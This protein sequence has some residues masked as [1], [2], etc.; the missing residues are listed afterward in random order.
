MCTGHQDYTNLNEMLL[1]IDVTAILDIT[2]ISGFKNPTT[3]RSL[4]ML[5]FSAGTGNR[6]TKSGGAILKAD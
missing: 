4:R 1:A 3:F 6:I 5:P 2:V